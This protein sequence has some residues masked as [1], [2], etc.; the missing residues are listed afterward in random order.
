[1]SFVAQAAPDIKQ[2]LQS[3]DDLQEKSLRHLVMVAAEVITIER[4][5]RK[6][7]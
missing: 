2:K 6:S 5:Q 7:K 4:I 1:M 3:L